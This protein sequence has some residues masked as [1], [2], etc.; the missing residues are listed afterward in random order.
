[1][2]ILLTGGAGFIGTTLIP[3]LLERHY[4]VTVVDNL[5][6]G[7]IPLLQFF[8]HKNFEFVKEDVRNKQ[9]IKA[10]CKDKD[11]IIHLAAI[12]GFGACRKDPMLAKEVNYLGTKTIASSIRTSQYIIFASTNTNYGAFK[13]KVCTEESPLNPQSIY[14]KTKTMAEEYL[15]A[16]TNATSYRFSTGFGVSPRLRLDVL[17]NE[18]VYH[19]VKE[20]YLVVYESEF[21][22][23]FIHVTDMA[24]AILFAIDHEQQMRGQVYNMGSEDMNVS[25]RD[26]CEVIRKM[27]GAYIHYAAVGKDVDQRNYLVSYKKVMN[28]GFRTSV[29]MK[30]GIEELVRAMEAIH[31]STPYTNG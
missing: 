28:L 29:T 3:L 11:V 20:K 30:Q 14:G 26:I 16:H 24:R 9:A 15:M 23:S 2:N 31:I 17:I 8:H 5:L 12:V 7:G 13:D 25:K 4:H 10:L 19:A 1:M 27:T 21:I 6:Y 18:F 22:R